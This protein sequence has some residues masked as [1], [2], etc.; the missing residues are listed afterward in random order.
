MKHLKFTS[1][2][3]TLALL[4]TLLPPALA[5]VGTSWDSDCR[6][7]PKQGGYGK[8]DWVKQSET[9][10]ENCTSK[11]TA[12]YRCSLCGANATRSTS[13]SDH[14]WG[15]WKTKKEATCTERG[16][17]TRT[18]KVCG[19]KE[20]RKTDR[21][22]HRWGEWTIIVDATDHSAGTRK[23]TCQVCGAES[24]EEF[25]PEGTLRR[26]DSGDAV[27]ALQEGL[28]CY[29]VLKDRADGSFG[30][31]T[32]K[33]IMA[34]QK[35]VGL[36]ADGV[37]WPQTR[38]LLGHRFGD[39]EVLQEMTDFSIGIRQRTCERCGYV[40]SEETWPE[41]TYRR[42]DKGDAV[43]ALQEGLSAAGY[44]CGRADGMFGGRTERAVKA[45]EETHGV[46][47]DGIAWPGVQKWLGIGPADDDR[48]EGVL[49]L[50]LSQTS[51]AQ[52]TYAPG[53]E[54][55][56]S[57][58]LI[59]HGPEDL[60]LD[61]VFMD[62]GDEGMFNLCDTPMTL[63]AG[64]GSAL[65]DTWTTE[66]DAEWIIDGAWNLM[67]FGRGYR[68]GEE[69][70][71]HYV[72]SNK[73]MV[74]LPAEGE[75][76]L[77]GREKSFGSGVNKMMKKGSVPVPEGPV[78]FRSLTITDQ[79]K[80]DDDYYDGAKIP[81]K[82]RLTIDTL[83]SYDLLGITAAPGDSVSKE[84]WMDGVLEPG[85][86]YDFTYT[87]VLDPEKTGWKNRDVIAHL[88]SHT[89]NTA[90]EELCEVRPPFTYPTVTLVG[91]NDNVID[92]PAFLYLKVDKGSFSGYPNENLNI[93]V[94]VTTNAADKFDNVRLHILTDW[95]EK[96]CYGV[97]RK[98]TNTMKAHET[99]SFLAHAPVR[100][101][102]GKWEN[103]TL[104][105]YA[106][107][108]TT[109]KKGNPQLIE[110]KRVTVPIEV[111]NP[112]LDPG[113]LTIKYL[114][115][116][117]RS[118]FWAHDKVTLT[119]FV[120][121]SG[122]TPIEDVHVVYT[123]GYEKVGD[124]LGKFDI[125][126]GGE[127]IMP[128]QR[129]ITDIKFDIPKS[130]VDEGSFEIGLM[131]SGKVK[132]TGKPV[133]SKQI[134][135][136]GKVVKP[137][138]KEGVSLTAS[139]VIPWDDYPT[140]TPL[141]AR[142]NIKN[143]SD[144]K[145]ENMRLYAV[146]DNRSV[147]IPD[148]APW[149]DL[150]HGAKGWQCS[151][152]DTD[153]EPGKS[154]TMDV[155]VRIPANYAG[156]VFSPAW[157]ADADL[158]DG[159]PVRSNPASLALPARANSL[160]MIVYKDDFTQEQ[161]EIGEQAKVTAQMEYSGDQMPEDLIVRYW[162]S[163]RPDA[164]KTAPAS[165]YKDGK[166][167]ASILLTMDAKDAV[168]GV[169]TWNFQG[170][171]EADP[172]ITSEVETLSFSMTDGP[173]KGTLSLEVEQIT[174]QA[175]S[176]GW[177]DSDVVT[178]KFHAVYEGEQEPLS[179]SVGAAQDS[180]GVWTHWK[181]AKGT[182]DFSDE[183]D[184]PL[185]ASRSVDGQATV[186]ISAYIVLDGAGSH[187][188]Y[189]EKYPFTFQLDMS[190]ETVK[191]LVENG[192]LSFN[193]TQLTECMNPEGWWYDGDQVHVRLETVYKRAEPLNFMETGVADPQ[194]HNMSEHYRKTTDAI[195]SDEIVLTL[196]ADQA[197]AGQCAYT[198]YARAFVTSYNV[199]D[200]TVSDVTLAFDMA[201]GGKGP[202]A[203]PD[204][205]INWDAVHDFT[206]VN[207]A[208]DGIEPA[209]SA[210][211]DAVKPTDGMDAVK[212]AD[213][214]GPGQ[215]MDGADTGKPEI[216]VSNYDFE[217]IDVEIP[218]DGHEIPATVCLPVGKGP[219][220]A[221]V[222]LHGTGST[223]NEAGDGYKYAAPIL[224]KVFGIATIRIDFPGNG[225]SQADYM[226]YDFHSAV[227]DAKAAANYMA[228]LESIDGDAIGVMGWSQGGTNALLACAWEP[229]TF[230]AVVTW[231]GA[232]DMMQDGF[233]TPEDYEEAREMGYFV[234]EFDWRDD[235]K[236]SLQ[237]CDDVANTD[238]LAE[239]AKGFS[240]PVL[241]IAGTD[242]TTV[243][244]VWSQRIAS[245]S[246]NERSAVYY[247]VGMDHTF[248]VF[249][250]EDLHSLRQAVDATGQFFVET[251]GNR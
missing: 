5:A 71:E 235:L 82:M 38:R 238:V 123:E 70:A 204:T 241:A 251:L 167:W 156:S 42:G 9:P 169:W 95:N 213:G 155:P 250:E 67:F 106:T 1:I 27:K 92:Y 2:I 206:D 173:V 194:G 181:D 36:A 226:Q 21:T 179:I 184:V 114:V 237:W 187:N 15:N 97:E 96:P 233:F 53:D 193:V 11:G 10:G 144:K 33:A 115:D 120:Y 16:E 170:A 127:A 58:T 137:I 128:G 201:P 32:E 231:A 83:D 23:H 28:I 151:N 190:D 101:I 221:V 44:D 19:K 110:S 62:Y 234:M 183:L 66:L 203:K 217:E 61:H 143:E 145:I 223:R 134:V 39:W 50:T 43:K 89:Y 74:S 166:A 202:E 162:S 41:P 122:D 77:S 188:I 141:Y 121:N 208:K 7:N 149:V 116:P 81:V 98:L 52:S 205:Q 49:V 102:E 243:D 54:V 222:M 104:T 4:L 46:T 248:N 239:F 31:G 147:G 91:G 87:M 78:G 57:W 90:E 24:T 146:G 94:T 136:Q 177:H 249:T 191:D 227:A 47:A 218:G 45:I 186:T 133:R 160:S 150:G 178:F 79:T 212:P 246:A 111:L 118:T 80:N 126:N 199:P 163:G 220:P 119:A 26:G 17:E 113:A 159:T 196:D 3:L 211:T 139:M 132:D 51:E 164:V 65:S 109:D 232:P 153:L 86:S 180:S 117:N 93:P 182:A 20:T 13:A 6:G 129:G 100:T 124:L 138:P 152:H 216:Y 14:R 75:D 55:S 85:K 176:N 230:K 59:N 207:G 8:H 185:D 25:D 125:V 103:Y 18:C 60:I 130:F 140:E 157:I 142:L 236:V 35:A 210:D 172:T 244:P 224:A 200:Y 161:C 22:P 69:Y 189:S 195:W 105:F 48:E 135:I 30:L 171:S 168:G 242:D 68:P 76:D 158:S 247:I 73:I 215:Y 12:Y 240:G 175:D 40:E 245:A 88:N 229:E 198:F 197:V 148:G 37:A 209:K 154:F 225:E 165:M 214:D 72:V 107:G 63:T 174:A 192:A 228:S 108:V 84:S 99:R 219:F 112:A 131:A 64:G 29:G 56:F 34:V